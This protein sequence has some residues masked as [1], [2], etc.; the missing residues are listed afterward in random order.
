[1]SKVQ[2]TENHQIWKSLKQ[3]I[4][5]IKTYLIKPLILDYYL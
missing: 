5:Y 2:N 3:K 4:E 1:M